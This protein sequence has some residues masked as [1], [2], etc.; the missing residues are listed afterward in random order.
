MSRD[1]KKF[2]PARAHMLDAPERERYLPTEAL[3]ALLALRGDELVVDYGAGTGRLVHAVAQRVAAGGELV[4]VEESEEMFERLAAQIAEVDNARAVVISGN[5]VPL[6]D[7]SAQRILAV[8]L[9]HE[10]R[11]ETAL[12]EMRRLLAPGGFLLAVDWE[13]GRDR[14]GGPPDE[15]LYTAAEA[16]TELALAGLATLI[17]DEQHELAHARPSPRERSSA[18]T[19]AVR[20]AIARPAAG[21]LALARSAALDLLPVPRAGSVALAQS[22]LGAIAVG[23]RR[24]RR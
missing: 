13:R 19:W 8:N 10:V 5:R 12:D 15:L 9:L 3:V 2:D 7:G 20:A 16:A 22:L 4:A 11:G 14:D 21:R 6:A 17:L 18:A 1:P 24:G 23:L